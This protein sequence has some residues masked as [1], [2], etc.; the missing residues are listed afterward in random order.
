MIDEGMLQGGTVNVS[1]KKDELHF[2]IKKQKK[3]RSKKAP[4]KR[5]IAKKIKAKKNIVKM[6]A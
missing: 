1:M 6:T 5:K 4:A 3:L 2:D